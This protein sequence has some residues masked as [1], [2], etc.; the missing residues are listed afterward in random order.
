M[1]ELC[2]YVI[3]HQN[4]EQKEEIPTRFLVAPLLTLIYKI[5][6]KIDTEI[7]MDEFDDFA[8]N[9]GPIDENK[10]PANMSWVEWRKH[11]KEM[12][13]TP[14]EREAAEARMEDRRKWRE[15]FPELSDDPWVRFKGKLA[16]TGKKYLP[17]KM[18]T[19]ACCCCFS[20]SAV[21]VIIVI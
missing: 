21:L 15:E 11:I 12:K 4:F 9:T 1:V 8:F 7:P 14:E 18:Q 13:Q 20:A 16:G 5:M 6:K 19:G 10:K 2:M 3:L 17:T